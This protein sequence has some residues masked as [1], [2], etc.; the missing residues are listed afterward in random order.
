MQL[1]DLICKMFALTFL[2]LSPQSWWYLNSNRLYLSVFPA[3][4]IDTSSRKQ[5]ADVSI[6]QELDSQA[7][8]LSHILVIKKGVQVEG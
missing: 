5:T 7:K 1:Y 4:I 6:K 8:A 2:L 3:F